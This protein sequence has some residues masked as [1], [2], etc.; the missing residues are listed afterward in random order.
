[1]CAL[2]LVLAFIS[3]F[4]PAYVHAKS[5]TEIF[6]IAF[7]STVVVIGYDGICYLLGGY[8]GSKGLHRADSP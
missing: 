1:M 8:I 6:D 7:K 4:I 3:A 5:A 2:P